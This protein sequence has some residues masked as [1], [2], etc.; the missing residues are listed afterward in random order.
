MLFRSL[1]WFRVAGTLVTE[2]LERSWTYSTDD[3]AREAA[4]RGEPVGAYGESIQRYGQ[5]VI[6]LGGNRWLQDEFQT[7]MMLRNVL[8]RYGRPTPVTDAITVPGDPRIQIGDCIDVID[9]DGLGG[10]T[11]LQILG[12]TRE[13]EDGLGLR[14]T[15]QV[16][17]IEVPGIGRWDDD[18]YGRWDLSLIW[19]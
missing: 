8:K 7:R 15:Y 12:V 4:Q 5:R 1:R 10:S 6:E 13:F 14:D 11:R 16:E 18:Q 9:P 2:D 19:N 17:V 3:V